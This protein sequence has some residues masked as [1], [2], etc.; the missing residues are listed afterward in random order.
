MLLFRILLLRFFKQ[1]RDVGC[2]RKC[3]RE[4]SATTSM[5]RGTSCI[6]ELGKTLRG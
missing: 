3:T 6:L 2:A 5:P 1:T 4:I